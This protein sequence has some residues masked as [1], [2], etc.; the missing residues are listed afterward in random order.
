MTAMLRV[1]ALSKTYASGHTAL[2]DVS[3]EV[4]PGEV[5]AVDAGEVVGVLG[6]HLQQVAAF[7]A[8]RLRRCG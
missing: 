2:R 5:L 3:L 7:D 1:H 4:Y 8:G 6:Q